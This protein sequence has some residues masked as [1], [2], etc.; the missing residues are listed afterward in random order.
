MGK[1]ARYT[2]CR[3][4]RGGEL[5]RCNVDT[6]DGYGQQGDEGCAWLHG[7]IVHCVERGAVFAWALTTTAAWCAVVAFSWRCG[8]DVVRGRITRAKTR[9]DAKGGGWDGGCVRPFGYKICGGSC[10]L[11]RPAVVLLVC[12]VALAERPVSS[13]QGA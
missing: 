1:R 11:M 9:G 6:R 4:S 8:G 12:V 7:G 10:G 2:H 5:P 13:A 3:C